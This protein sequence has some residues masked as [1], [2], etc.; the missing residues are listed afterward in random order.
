MSGGGILLFNEDLA[1][2]LCYVHGG[3]YLAGSRERHMA[4]TW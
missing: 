4:I 2:C 3:M 1:K